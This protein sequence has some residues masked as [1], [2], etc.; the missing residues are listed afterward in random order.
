M[1]DSIR[2]LIIKDLGTQ[3]AKVTTANGYGYDMSTPKRA[4]RSIDTRDYPVSVYFPQVEENE[5]KFGKDVLD[6]FFRVESH[7]LI[8][9]ADPSVLQEK[10][11]ADLRKN[12][13]N[14]GDKWTTYADD[15]FYQGGGPAEQPEATDKVTAVYLLIG[16]KYKTNIGDPYNN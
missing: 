1:A 11:L 7:M 4:K 6:T 16:V 10:M 5:R 12:L 8:G 2:E 14:P 3:L 9:S 13:T 15:L